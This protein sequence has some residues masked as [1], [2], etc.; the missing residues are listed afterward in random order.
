[1]LGLKMGL[2]GQ[3][4]RFKKHV[5]NEVDERRVLTPGTLLPLEAKK[6]GRPPQ[7]TDAPPLPL[8]AGLN[9]WLRC[10]IALPSLAIE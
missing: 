4:K 8:L 5:G 3:Q 10:A 9:Q 1:M 6:H 2:L 7:T